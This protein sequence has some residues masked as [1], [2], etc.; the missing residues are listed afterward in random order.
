M[1]ND[2]VSLQAIKEAH[3]N[4]YSRLDKVEEKAELLEEKL[5]KMELLVVNQ[6]HEIKEL[7]VNTIKE[8][9]TPIVDDLNDVKSRPMKLLLKVVLSALGFL[10]TILAGTIIW[11]VQV[12]FS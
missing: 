5:Q 12:L 2:N 10:G 4:I 8:E 11:I 3:K 7:L 9:M 6:N 1:T